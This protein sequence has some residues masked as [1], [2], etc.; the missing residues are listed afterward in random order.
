MYLCHGFPWWLRGKE[1]ASNVGDPVLI[2]RSGPYPGE[3]CGNPLQY[4]YLE[5]PWIEEPE[6]LQSMGL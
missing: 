4:S 3:G 2:S 1:V 5:N 6:S